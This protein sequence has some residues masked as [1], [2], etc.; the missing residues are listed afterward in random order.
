M[1]VVTDID[2]VEWSA[3]VAK[4]SDATFFQTPECFDFY[5]SLSFMTPFVY[6]VKEDNKLCAVMV[7]YVIADGGIIKRFLSRRAIVPGGILMDNDCSTGA[8]IEL[9]KYAATDLRKKAIYVEIRNYNDYSAWKQVFANAGFSY[10]EH[11]NFHVP[12]TD[13]DFALKQLSTTKRRDIKI[14]RKNGGEVSLA[15]NEKEVKEYF[16]L[17]KQLYQ[18]KVKTPLFPYEFFE[19]LYRLPEGRLFVVKYEGRVVGGSACVELRGR[20]LY[21]WFVCGLDREVKNIFPSTLATW[22]AIEY[23]ATHNIPLFDMMGAGKPDEGY[24]VRDFKAKFG[25]ILVEHGRFIYVCSKFLYKVGVF[26]LK[27]M[28][29]IK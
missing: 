8:L 5:K 11:L 12:T 28:K 4:V 20:A 22:G 14:T 6:G 27:I 25:G 23:A 13:L 18:T 10:V 17:L 1:E 3:L 26:G 29:K 16:E 7:G 24:G 9:L 2:R 19:K 15:S 21:E